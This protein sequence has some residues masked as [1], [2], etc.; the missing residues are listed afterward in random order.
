MNLKTKPGGREPKKMGSA[1]APSPPPPRCGG[2]KVPSPA[3]PG[4]ERHNRHG[5]DPGEAPAGMHRSAPRHSAGVMSEMKGP[6]ET[7]RQ[8]N[9]RCA[10]EKRQ[11]AEKETHEE[12]EKIEIRPGHK[13]PR[14]RHLLSQPTVAVRALEFET[15]T[16]FTAPATVSRHCS[17]A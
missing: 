15:R 8:M 1:K 2:G 7:S 16:L 17:I 6:V 4:K 11:Y 3:D 13:P 9:V 14:A 5:V 12:A 10:A